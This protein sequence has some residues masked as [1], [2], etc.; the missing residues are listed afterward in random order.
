MPFYQ[1]FR[2]SSLAALTAG[3]FV[4]DFYATFLPALIP[5]LVAEKGL[6]LTASG[7]LVLVGSATANVLQPFF[8]YVV[9]RS[10]ATAL[11]LWSLPLTAA[12][13]CTINL[14]PSY[15]WLLLFVAISG[16]G[17]SLFHPIASSLTHKITARHNPGLSLSIFIGGG[18]FGFAVAPALVTLWLGRHGFDSLPWL[19]I[20]GFLLTVVLYKTQL[21]KLQLIRK[22]MAALSGQAVW[23][24]QSG[25][26]LLNAAMG[27]RSWTQVVLMTFLPVFL[28]QQAHYSPLAASAYLTLFL[29]GGAFGGLAGGYFGDKIGYKR[30][31][32]FSLL[33]ALFCYSG[34]Y[35]LLLSNNPFFAVFLFL[36]GA[37]LQSSMPSSI[38]WAQVLL[39]QNRSLASGMMLGLSNGIGGLGAAGSGWLADVYS[40]QLM[41][42]VTLVPLLLA[43]FLTANTP[44]ADFSSK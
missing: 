33:L 42:L 12:F 8:G 31:V 6:S 9:D 3:H 14:A 18:N 32:L 7:I 34:L 38:I 17:T 36:T 21:H 4:S 2:H 19:M 37:L 24:R 1:R 11:L 43:V 41:L 27:L 35:W 44:E 26:W 10:G 13:I 20:P 25:I 30:S 23:Y 5:L 40:L 39:P 22:P 28:I 29:I 16:I 15:S